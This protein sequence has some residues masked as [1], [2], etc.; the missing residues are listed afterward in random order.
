MQEALR[1]DVERTFGVIQARFA[2]VS[3]PART[4]DDNNM[5]Y[6]MKACIILHNM[7]VVDECGMNLENKYDPHN[8]PP[9]TKDDMTNEEFARFLKQLHEI[10]DRAIGSCLQKDLVEHLWQWQGDV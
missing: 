8:I 7:I 10:Q 6:I 2:M 9:R 5:V 4:W 1:K 3:R